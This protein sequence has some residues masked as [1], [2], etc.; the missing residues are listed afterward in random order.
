[1][2][3]KMQRFS[4]LKKTIDSY[5][6]ISDITW[7][8][9]KKIST[10]RE[11]NKNDV[12][13]SVGTIPKSFSFV[14]Q[15][16]LRAYITDTNGSEYNKIFFPE[17]TFPGAMV[18]LLT[19]SESRFTIDALEPS[20]LIE[21][22][23]RGYRQLLMEYEDLKIF[24]IHYLEA[25]WLIAKDIREVALVQ[26]SARERYQ[27]FQYE[28][29]KLLKRLPQYHIASHLGITPTQLSRIRKIKP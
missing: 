4:L 5:A 18:A 13:N 14:C 22:D 2:A 23:F 25:N 10:L 24:H 28:H 21:I 29:P 17:T 7:Q 16:L 8:G 6:P 19:N 15:G 3:T 1:M 26:E 11:L 27:R 20:I 12:F 9:L